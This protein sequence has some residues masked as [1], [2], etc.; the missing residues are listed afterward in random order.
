MK[1]ALFILIWSAFSLAGCAPSRS[2]SPEA[3]FERVAAAAAKN[4]WKTVF[5][6][7]DPEKA[8]H[9]LFGITV[10]VSVAASRD[11]TLAVEYQ[12]IIRLHGVADVQQGRDMP[13]SDETRMDPI[14]RAMFAKVSNKPRYFAEMVRAYQKGPHEPVGREFTGTLKDLKLNGDTATGTVVEF[15]GKNV[16]IGFVKRGSSWYVGPAPRK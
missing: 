8:D 12:A 13:L 1:R 2:P 11:K 14:V 16:P 15:D 4:D 5:E 6:C 7:I 3:V 10:D 9:I